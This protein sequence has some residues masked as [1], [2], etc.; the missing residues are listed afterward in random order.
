MQSDSENGA[1]TVGWGL[2]R[3]FL[4]EVNELY[5]FFYRQI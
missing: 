4:E 1:F 5:A 2:R 3:D